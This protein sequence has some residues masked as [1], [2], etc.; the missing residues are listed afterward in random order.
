MIRLLVKTHVD[1]LNRK[2][3]PG[4]TLGAHLAD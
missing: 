1:L 2:P 3:A 4:H